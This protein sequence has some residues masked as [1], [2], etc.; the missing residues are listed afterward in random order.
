[1]LDREVKS[2]HSWTAYVGL[3]VSVRQSGTWRGRG[4][5]TKRG[6]AYIRKRLF[7]AA[8]GACLNYDYVRAYYDRLKAEGRKHVEAV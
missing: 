4:K 2:A 7:Q 6:N 8:W 1:M 5:L 3:D